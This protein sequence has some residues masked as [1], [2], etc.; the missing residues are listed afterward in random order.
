MTALFASLFAVRC[1]V[2]LNHCLFSSVARSPLFGQNRVGDAKTRSA[3]PPFCPGAFGL[4]TFSPP[5]LSSIRLIHI[6]SL[7]LI[8]VHPPSWIC[9]SASRGR[10]S[11]VCQQPPG[12]SDSRCVECLSVCLARASPKSRLCC[13]SCLPA[14]VSHLL[15]S[16]VS[17]PLPAFCLVPVCL[18][19]PYEGNL[20]RLFPPLFST[21]VDQEQKQLYKS[22]NLVRVSAAHLPIDVLMSSSP[23]SGPASPGQ[24]KIDGP[25][26]RSPAHFIIPPA[27]ALP[28]PA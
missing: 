23:S 20:R 14:V 7:S 4:P 9:Q 21:R 2:P 13:L 5:H 26:L 11:C 25:Y 6:A 24:T 1:S 27:L 18:H 19:L 8:A 10:E 3:S 15:I 16:F 28:S 22:R 17:L 12:G